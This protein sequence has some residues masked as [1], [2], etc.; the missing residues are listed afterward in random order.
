M[1]RQVLLAATTTLLFCACDSV[2]GVV[3]TAPESA[4]TNV[5]AR[6]DFLMAQ[7]DIWI[8]H[9]DLMARPMSGAAWERLKQQADAAAG[10][11]NLKDQNQM[12]NVYVLAKALV[13]ARTGQT[14][15]RDEVRAQCMAAIGT[16]VGGGRWRW[17]ARLPRM[18][19]PPGWWP[20]SQRKT[21]SFAA[22]CACV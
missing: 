22:G 5:G 21:L 7:R 12:N 2:T 1:V 9:K 15:Y 14:R 16:E 18:S 11:P 17:A 3:G 20:W 6:E 4:V 10:V 13:Y 19:S 8:S